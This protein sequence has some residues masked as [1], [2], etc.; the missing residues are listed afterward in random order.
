M[1]TNTSKKNNWICTFY[2]NRRP[3]GTYDENFDFCKWRIPDSHDYDS[4]FKCFQG[5]HEIGGNTERDHIQV[6]ISTR[7]RKRYGQITERCGLRPDQVHYKVCYVTP[8]KAW[9]YCSEKKG[10][11]ER[12]GD[13]RSGEEGE[14]GEI[15]DAEEDSTRCGCPSW[16]FGERPAERGGRRGGGRPGVDWLGIRD[17]ARC[18]IPER[19][20]LEFDS[21]VELIRGHYQYFRWAKSVLSAPQNIPSE[22]S[23]RS[24]IVY[25]GPAGCGKSKRVRE[26]C[27]RFKLDLWV[28]PL[29]PIGV[30]YDGY[31]GHSAALF[32]DFIGGMPFRDLLNL[33]EGNE[34]RVQVKGSYVTFKPSVVFFTSDRPWQQWMFPKGPDHGLGPMSAEEAEQLGRRITHQEEMRSTRT[35]TQALM[36]TSSLS[37]GVGYN[38]DLAHTPSADTAFIDSILQDQ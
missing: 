17:L 31:D 7:D 10:L 33:L 21:A 19:R 14:A 23:H 22:W 9:D 29:G 27:F 13:H 3:D 26:E 28:A 20:I 1:D 34:V 11:H 37:V 16:S 25:F 18:G 8:A 32:D 2:P 15:R 24:V 30:W 36:H 12:T 6:F 5:Q 4:F 38:T 35:I